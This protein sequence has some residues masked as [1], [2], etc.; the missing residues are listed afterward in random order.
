MNYRH[1]ECPMDISIFYEP[2]TIGP[3]QPV[4]ALQGRSA[5]GVGYWH[6]LYL[7]TSEGNIGRHELMSKIKL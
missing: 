4:G 1:D 5:G 6:N 3:T 7:D 2:L